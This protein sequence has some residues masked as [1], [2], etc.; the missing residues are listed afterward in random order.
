MDTVGID[1]MID[2]C[3][4]LMS[5]SDSWSTVASFVFTFLFVEM[6]CFIAVCVHCLLGDD[7]I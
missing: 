6:W 4:V 7:E 3:V 1:S 2:D 5:A